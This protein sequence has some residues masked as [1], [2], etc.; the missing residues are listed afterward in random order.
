MSNDSVASRV[1]FSG[2]HS[3]LRK[4]K[5]GAQ[6]FGSVNFLDELL[7]I[8]EFESQQIE[9]QS[10]IPS[11]PANEGAERLEDQDK[12]QSESKNEEKDE[13]VT[14]IA[15]QAP[16]SLPPQP[17]IEEKTSEAFDRTLEPV[18]K[19]PLSDQSSTVTGDGR[20]PVEVA[21]ANPA[22][23]SSVGEP[24]QREIEERFRLDA[25]KSEP[26]SD[27]IE[28]I[29]PLQS[30]TPTAESPAVSDGSGES[31][32]AK[33]D[34]GVGLD[35]GDAVEVEPFQASQKNILPDEP[36]RGIEDKQ[37]SIAA[38]GPPE[39]YQS[40]DSLEDSTRRLPDEQAAVE[41]K[42][43]RGRRAERLTR[44]RR[45]DGDEDSRQSRLSN[46]NG[47][48]APSNSDEKSTLSASGE[49]SV[50]S[51][52]EQAVQSSITSNVQSL[53]ALNTTTSATQGVVPTVTSG[54]QIGPVTSGASPSDK[55]AVSQNKISAIASV[56]S[57]N[58]SAASSIGATTVT[59]GQSVL[60]RSVSTS[61]TTSARGSGS[62]T[63][64]Q[65]TKLVQR[66]L[67]GLEQLGEGG[68]QVKLR[69]HPP[70][71]GTLQLT[72][73]IESGQMFAQMEVENSL[74][75]DAL[76]GNVQTLKDRL[77]TQ[78]MQIETF[79]VQL[80]ND[81]PNSSSNGAFQQSGF[82]S[83]SR[84]EQANSRYAEMNRNRI[85]A[86]A[87]NDSRT[88]AAASWTRKNGSLDLT[89]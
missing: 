72:L 73:R 75:R 15:I 74:A 1:I 52:T 22:K 67:R 30:L 14:P 42:P 85:Q 24:D 62:I 19:R 70:E 28:T 88:P 79:D 83:E 27:D 45:G 44:E 3:N 84:W 58:G 47:P 66:V 4:Q 38:V 2:I 12:E 13:A 49:G 40:N 31:T 21:N 76:L 48:I 56:E 61:T 46:S 60:T 23:L 35:S 71:L 81:S 64:Y 87:N 34:A 80:A 8:G 6:D 63:P 32:L 53:G 16:V 68:G 55:A 7:S 25:N 51:A 20:S 86:E 65:E 37:P 33:S 69:L 50:Q 41:A 78:G 54:F 36:A 57:A 59:A 89:V 5:D 29:S 26:V 39:N 43:A 11:V 77:A 82:G 17:I 10:T 18:S 9:L